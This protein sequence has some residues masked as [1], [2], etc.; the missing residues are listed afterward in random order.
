MKERREEEKRGNKTKQ[1]KT[2]DDSKDTFTSRNHEDTPRKAIQRTDQ[3]GHV[4][5]DTKSSATITRQFLLFDIHG[6]WRTPLF[7]GGHDARIICDATRK[8]SADRVLLL[9]LR[10]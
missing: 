7:D 5:L 8:N 9:S 4:K 3:T 10:R 2:P 1:N 6:L